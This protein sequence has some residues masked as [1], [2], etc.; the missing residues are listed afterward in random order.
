MHPSIHT[1]IH[2]SIQPSGGSP[3]AL[4]ADFVICVFARAAG[5][6]IRNNQPTTNN[7]NSKSRFYV[8]LRPAGGP[9]GTLRIS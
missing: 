4:A 9:E 1:S 7:N 5:D 8:C 6:E 2:P 3:I